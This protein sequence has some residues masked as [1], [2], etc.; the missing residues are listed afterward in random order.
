MGDLI[1]RNKAS[2]V[3]SHT[4]NVATLAAAR[5]GNGGFGA[6]AVYTRLEAA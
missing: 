1:R 3:G 6:C 2:H 5:A 4:H